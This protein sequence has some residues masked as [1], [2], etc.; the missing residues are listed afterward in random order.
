MA[1]VKQPD[2]KVLITP[3]FNETFQA[4]GLVVVLS[5]QSPPLEQF[6]TIVTFP[7]TPNTINLEHAVQTFDES[8]DFPIVVNAEVS[9]SGPTW[10]VGR[11]TAGTI[12]LTYCVSLPCDAV[13]PHISAV[14]LYCDQGGLLGSGSAFIPVPPT[15]TLYRNVV[16]WDLSEA[17]DGS[18]AMWTFGEGPAPV[19]KIGPAKILS[20][21]VFMVGPIHSNPPTP[22]QGSISDYYGYYWFGDL[23]PNIK[24]IK[25]IHHA[26]FLKICAFF[27][28]QP[29]AINP[30]RS[31]VLYL[32]SAKGF[33]ASNFHRSQIF[34]YDDQ[35]GEAE[36]YDLVR[37][38]A[39]EMA[40]NWLGP[41]A[42]DSGI[43]WLYDGIK[44]CLS[45]YFPFRN[46]FRTGHYFQSTVSMLCTRYYTNPY[47]SL[48]HDELLKLVSKDAYA[49][50][51]L[52]ARA[53]AFVLGTDLRGRRLSEL[54]RP[55]EDLAIIPMSKKRTKGEPYGI[56]VWLELLR[57]LMG[58]EAKQRYD[59]M[60]A[61]HVILFPTDLFGAKTHHLKQ[62][63][64]EVLDFGMD[65]ES[66]EERIVK[67]LKRGSRAEEAGLKEGD[68]IVKSSYL[69]KCVD[70][71]TAKMKVV[72][73]REG[74]PEEIKI[75]Y[76]PRS[77][78]KAK[79]WQ[80]LK[81]GEEWKPFGEIQ[82]PI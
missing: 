78:E 37:R 35:I 59:D 11:R 60:L 22:L 58:D 16:E 73:K 39:Y 80:M 46:G 30:Y 14:G 8:G 56:E 19:E 1:E 52:I 82:G 32:G 67:G 68:K 6:A 10:V 76:W 4:N 42:P 31:F 66:F 49:T 51:M 27:Q 23:P 55:I 13:K 26:F 75:E 71:Y 43:D 25:D 44:N 64:M 34:G 33:G 48:P 21:S 61:G 54:K 63:D 81:V 5:I 53:W 50:E 24:V 74:P 69:W 18:R 65:R 12:K 57:P 15:D 28:D 17:P 20:N 38:I 7:S 77:F 62:V 45:I 47:V 70:D 3:Q 36:D 79:G 29:S 40:H 72:V 2:L 41:T 9:G